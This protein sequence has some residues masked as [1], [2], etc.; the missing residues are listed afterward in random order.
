MADLSIFAKNN[1]NNIKLSTDGE[2]QPSTGESPYSGFLNKMKTFAGFKNAAEEEAC[3]EAAYNDLSFFGKVKHFIQN[4]LEVEKSY[5]LFFIILATGMT[6]ILISLM[7]LPIAWMSPQ[8]FVSFFSLGAFTTLI[9]FIF[10]YGT[11]GYLEMLFSKERI[12]FTIVFLLSIFLGLYFAFVGSNY[13]LS[14]ICAVVQ[15]ITLITFTLSFIPGGS[16][17]INFITGMLMTPITSAIN[18][19]KGSES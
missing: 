16:V 5:K 14:L 17:G 19:I 2:S 4:F 13:I 7:F 8:K 11:F 18:K 6:L 15:L 9:S 1:N 12:Y 3:R 10:I